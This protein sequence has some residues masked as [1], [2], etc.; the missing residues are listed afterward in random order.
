MFTTSVV[1]GNLKYPL[2]IKCLNIKKRYLNL[3][4][5]GYVHKDTGGFFIIT[6]QL[7]T[8]IHSYKF[9]K[10]LVIISKGQAQISQFKMYLLFLYVTN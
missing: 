7:S 1:R 8:H 10:G 9:R 3:K 6:S 2:R 5:L 4:P